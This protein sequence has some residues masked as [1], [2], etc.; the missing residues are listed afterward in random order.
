VNVGASQVAGM[1]VIRECVDTYR[2]RAVKSQS[3]KVLYPSA[4]C[5]WNAALSTFLTKGG[6]RR[7]TLKGTENLTKRYKIA[8]ACLS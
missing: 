6:L 2:A 5:T 4:A 8:A 3:G 7:A 1:N